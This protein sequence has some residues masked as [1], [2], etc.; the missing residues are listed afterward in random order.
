MIRYSSGETS[1]FRV[2]PTPNEFF[3]PAEAGLRR[4][5]P[6]TMN[7]CL[8]RQAF[9]VEVLAVMPSGEEFVGGFAVGS[10]ICGP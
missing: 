6:Y 10:G 4:V 3:F 8:Q 2:P 9:G 1:E 5:P 7:E